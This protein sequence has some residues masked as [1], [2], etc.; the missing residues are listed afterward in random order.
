MKKRLKKLQEMLKQKFGLDLLPTPTRENLEVGL[1]EDEDGP[2]I[3][4]AAE[5]KFIK[6]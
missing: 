4:T 5:L 6:L 1:D 3:V 2:T